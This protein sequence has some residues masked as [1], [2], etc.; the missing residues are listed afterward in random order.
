MKKVI[1]LAVLLIGLNGMAQQ[2]NERPNRDQIEKMTPEQRQEKQLKR[3]TSDLNLN[4]KQQEEVKKLMAEQNSKMSDL[5]AKKEV[6]KNEQ[7]LANSKERKEMA[8]KMKVEKEANDA[9]MKAILTKDQYTKWENNR[10]MQQEKMMERRGERNR[11][12]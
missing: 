3:L 10:A 4:A 1:M 6:A 7:L 5:R 11:N 12:K 2:R 8:E 9:K